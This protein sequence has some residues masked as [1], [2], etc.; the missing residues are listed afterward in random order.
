MLF[1]MLRALVCRSCIDLVL[2]GEARLF[3]GLT[4]VLLLLL[5][6]VDW[7]KCISDINRAKRRMA[8]APFRLRLGFGRAS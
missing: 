3:V 7:P 4:G 6:R 5:V 2:H 1:L 8:L